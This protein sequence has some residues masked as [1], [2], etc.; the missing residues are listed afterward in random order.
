M[1]EISTWF[2]EA[3]L[4]L[5]LH[6]GLY[7]VAAGEWNGRKMEVGT[8]AEQ[9]GGQL[10]IPNREYELL[11]QQFSAAGFDADRWVAY[12]LAADARYMVLTAKHQD[13]FCLFKTNATSY[14]SVEATPFGRDAVGELSEA[15]RRAGLRFGVYYSHARDHHQAG[16]NWNEHGNTWDFKPQTEDDFRE[17]FNNYALK[18]VKELCSNYGQLSVLWFDVPYRIP[19]DLSRALRETVKSLQPECLIS[20]RIGNGFGDYESW[21]DNRYPEHHTEGL[22]ECCLTMNNTWG[23]SKYDTDFKKPGEIK[24]VL[25]KVNTL[26]GNLLLNVGPTGEGTFPPQAVET[27][28][29]LRSAFR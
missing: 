15:C 10:K 17:Y 23:Y 9:I 25:K 27:L 11:A 29:H 24:R 13:G 12:A 21:P 4:G 22:W 7:S 20:S 28:I 6:W 5:F 26:G 2:K 1:S 8:Y 19:A 14:N 3:K 18:Q 16:A